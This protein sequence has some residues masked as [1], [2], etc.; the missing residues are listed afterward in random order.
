MNEPCNFVPNANGECRMQE[1]LQTADCAATC[2]S[3]VVTAPL[4]R[5]D[6]ACAAMDE[7]GTELERRTIVPL[8]HEERGRVRNAP[9]LTTAEST[10]G[11]QL[12]LAAAA[13]AVV[14]AI[15][16]AYLHS[17]ALSRVFRPTT[18]GFV[19]PT[20]MPLSAAADS[21]ACR[22]RSN[23]RMV[24]VGDVHGDVEGLKTILRGAGLI[25][26]D[27]CTRALPDGMANSHA[28]VVQVGDIVDRGE[29]AFEA[30]ECMSRLQSTSDPP[31]RCC[32]AVQHAAS[33]KP[34]TRAAKAGNWLASA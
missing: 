7:F 14:A 28:I 24:F 6:V 3:P 9:A 22:L 4:A 34:S 29:R 11:H 12:H 2:G 31:S 26:D 18:T 19:L 33:N 5:A 17:E 27:Q 10:R 32:V 30:Y 23:Q 1:R 21:A 8:P 20:A 13:L 25:S 16:V 15:A